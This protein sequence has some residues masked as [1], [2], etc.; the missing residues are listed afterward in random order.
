MLR[1]PTCNT[2]VQLVPDYNFFDSDSIYEMSDPE[3]TPKEADRDLSGM[4]S[5]DLGNDNKSIAREGE[6]TNASTPVK[7]KRIWLRSLILFVVILAIGGGIYFAFSYYRAE[8]EKNTYAYQISAAREA[9]NNHLTDEALTYAYKA[10]T[11][12]ADS[13]EARFLIV[14]IAMEEKDYDTAIATLKEILSIDS[15]HKNAFSM[16]LGIYDTLEDYDSIYALK[17]AELSENLA[18]LLD[19]YLLDAPKASIAGG[20]YDDDITITLSASEGST[21]YYTL[22]GSTP[23]ENA[24]VY[25]GEGIAISEGKTTICAI[26]FD[27]A[28]R[29]SEIMQEEYEIVYAIPEEPTVSPESG[30]FRTITFITIGVPNGCTCYYTLDGSVPSTASTVYTGPF[31][32]PQ[33]DHI[34]SV[35]SVKNGQVSNVVTRTYTY[36]PEITVNEADQTSEQTDSQNTTQT[37][38]N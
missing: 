22:D 30:T 17:D 2:E 27:D 32:M 33:G 25:E 14:D 3:Q 16:L 20:T 7:K 28:G 1:C 13:L 26:A 9:Y 10:L 29:Y 24:S 5:D 4:I 35:V 8:Q 36:L 31:A 19:G 23:D 37:T 11:F 15:D 6:A 34:L 12:E 21:V 38:E 18:D